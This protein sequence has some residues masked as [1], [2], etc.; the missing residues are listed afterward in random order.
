MGF[1]RPNQDPGRTGPGWQRGR[2]PHWARTCRVSRIYGSIVHV[3]ATDG[4]DWS[5]TRAAGGGSC[6]REFE[7]TQGPSVPPS[8]IPARQPVET[9]DS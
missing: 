8:S 5:S 4:R 7:C 9:E 6:S 2:Q 3:S 1:R